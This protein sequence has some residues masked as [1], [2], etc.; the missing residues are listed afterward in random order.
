MATSEKKIQITTTSPEETH[1]LGSHIGRALTPGTV[2]FLSGDLGCGKTAFVQGLARGLDVP[3]TYYVTS[4][5]FSI[6]NEYPGRVTLFHL[7]IYRLMDLSDLDDIGFD[8][9][10]SG[11]GV[12]AI[13]WAEKFPLDFLVP[14]I[15]IHIENSGGSK[16]EFSIIIYGQSNPDLLKI[17]V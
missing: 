16:R 11:E 14:D 8:D 15:A 9:I 7:D 6:V 17:F 4:P 10:V 5:T 2:I 3:E 13:E 1:S 12:V